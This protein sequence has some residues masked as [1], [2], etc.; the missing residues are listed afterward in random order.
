MLF[1]DCDSSLGCLA[2]EFYLS[3]DLDQ[4]PSLEQIN[5]FNEDFRY[6]RASVNQWNQP[7]MYMDV[8]MRDGGIALR[9]VDA[10]NSMEIA[11]VFDEFQPTKIVHLAAIARGEILSEGEAQAAMS[12]ILDGFA[13]TAQIGAL[14]CGL[15][16]RGEAEDELVG[17]A[18]AIR[19][20]ATRIRSTSASS[21]SARSRTATSWCGPSP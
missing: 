19:A 20:R 10:R 14:L 13:T 3:Y 5:Q 18:R 7:T 6:I 11:R 16:L 15:A 9:N 1:L 12:S 17:F 8:L 4:V 2:V 21:P